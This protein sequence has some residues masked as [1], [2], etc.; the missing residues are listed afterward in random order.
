MDAYAYVLEQLRR[1]DCHRLRSYVSDGRG[2]FTTWLV[3]VARR[4]CIDYIRQRYGREAGASRRNLVDLLVE[5]LDP[6]DLA[7]HTSPDPETSLRVHE[8]SGAL[9][10][11]L[12]AL[13]ARDRLLLKLRFEDDLPAR[14][15]GQIMGFRTPFHVYRRLNAL[16]ERLR[17]ALGRRG[18]Q[19]SEP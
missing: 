10:G 1:D 2:K 17:T 18:V 14:E 13:D 15:I 5:Q 19:G 7:D 3:V 4:L 16:L 9:G 12:G 8:L 11:A 6:A